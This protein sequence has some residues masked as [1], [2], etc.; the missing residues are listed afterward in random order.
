MLSNL[1]PR[2]LHGQSSI[3]AQKPTGQ[4]ET[5]YRPPNYNQLIRT[6]AMN[7]KA[8]FVSI[9]DSA[10]S[11]RQSNIRREARVTQGLSIKPPL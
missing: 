8:L 6:W 4:T 1:A 9:S 5:T 10:F 11:S 2:R 3:P 7:S